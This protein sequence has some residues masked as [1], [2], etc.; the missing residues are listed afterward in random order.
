MK[1]KLVDYKKL[2]HQIA[3][4]LLENYP[5]GYGDSDIISFKN[6]SGE[7]IEAVEV[8][9]NDTIYM[10]KIS[11][12]LTYFIDNFDATVANELNKEAKAKTAAKAALEKEHGET[13]LLN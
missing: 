6:A 13:D 1:R 2:D 10:V 12:S 7:I 8:R 3:N 5:H 11:Q 4:L 9:T